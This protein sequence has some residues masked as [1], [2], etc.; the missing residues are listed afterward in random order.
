MHRKCLHAESAISTPG[1]SRK[2]G[3]SNHHRGDGDKHFPNGH[4]KTSSGGV[5]TG[6]GGGLS[7]GQL[8]NTPA[9][10]GVAAALAAAAAALQPQPT[11]P[12]ASKYTA[13]KEPSPTP[14]A[15]PF[16]SPSHSSLVSQKQIHV[17]YK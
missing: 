2:S 12:T 3:Q 1:A 11:P 17:H 16:D 5:V 9:P 6:G 10:T 15:I 13:Q 14:P 8:N 4:P 7:D